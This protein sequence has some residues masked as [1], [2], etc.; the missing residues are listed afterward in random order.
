LK[1][2]LLQATA[3]KIYELQYRVQQQKRLLGDPRSRLIHNLLHL[4]HSRAALLH[5]F[6]KHLSAC[7][8]QVTRITGRL[9]E[10]NPARQVEHKRQWLNEQVRQLQIMMGMQLTRKITALNKSVSVLTAVSPRAVLDRGYSIV[11]SKPA[12]ELIYTSKQTNIGQAVEVL[13]GEG[14]IGC[15]VTEIVEK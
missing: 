2:R 3:R 14:S 13:L 15:E 5:A 4:D 11:R 12:G 8:S 6:E 10:Q 9:N 7:R 1:E